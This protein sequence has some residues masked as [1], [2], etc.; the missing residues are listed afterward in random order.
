LGGL[1]FVLGAQRHFGI[2]ASVLG[3]IF[4][5]Q[6]ANSIAHYGTSFAAARGPVLSFVA[7]SILFVIG[8]LILFTPKLMETRRIG[9]AKYGQLARRLGKEF[10]A[11]WVSSAH[12]QESMLGS[13]DPS[14]LID[15][16]SSYDVIR[17]MQTIPINRQL[18][19]QVT[20]QAAAPLAL[21]W[22]IMS[23]SEKIVEILLKILT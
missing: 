20:I 8:P 5:G 14:T 3:S 6:Y 23:P 19:I 10:A 1:G 17:Q 4:A 18:V 12:P 2:L 16:V 11:K 7:V 13:P 21:V 9:L 15:Y 22:L